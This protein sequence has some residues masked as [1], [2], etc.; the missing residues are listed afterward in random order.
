MHTLTIQA[1]MVEEVATRVGV[2]AMVVVAA[3]ADGTKR[4]NRC[5]Y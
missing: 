2:A 3:A 1:A 5:C 4:V